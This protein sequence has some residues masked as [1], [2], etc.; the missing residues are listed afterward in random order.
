MATERASEEAALIH[1]AVEASL[2]TQRR[3][4]D[5]E[6]MDGILAASNL[7]ANSL[8]ADGKLLL[9]GN[10]GSAA[11]ATHVAAEFV[12]RFLLERRALPALSLSDNASAVTAVSNDYGFEHVF[13]RQIESV[14]RPGDVALAI[15]T[16]GE[17]ANV[18]RGVEAA[19]R[20]GLRTVG[21]TGASGGRLR[22]AADVCIAV[23]SH[24]T[25]RIQE[26]HTLVAHLLCELVERR[27]A[28]YG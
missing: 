25:P 1:E 11:D 4:L 16:S 12:G 3:L 22:E 10:G 6:C 18:L 24:A 17:S 7:I 15:S 21:L 20:L 9:F 26:A 23:A 19:R 28:A 8:L 27:V 13:A 14:G 5:A 2:E